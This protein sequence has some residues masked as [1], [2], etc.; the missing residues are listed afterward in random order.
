MKTLTILRHAKSSWSNRGLPDHERPLNRRGEKDAPA[1][2]QRIHDAGIR[3]S[4]VMS[5]PAVRAWCTAKIVAKAINYP[6]E[7]LHREDELYL[8]GL[9]RLL[10]LISRQDNAFNSIMIVGHNPGLTEFANYLLPDVTDN[11]P[12][13]GLVAANI[14]TDNWDLRQGKAAELVLYDYPKNPTE[15][16]RPSDETRD[17]P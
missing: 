5:S 8:A 17:H 12:T 1:M 6:V 7:F 9:D 14:D 4:L 16:L 11:I 2:A 3:P 10:D 15:A 13:C